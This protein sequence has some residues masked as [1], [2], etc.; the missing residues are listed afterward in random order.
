MGVAPPPQTKVTIAG[1]NDIC[2]REIWSGQFWYTKFWVPDPPP[3]SL[4]ILPCGRGGGGGETRPLGP[5]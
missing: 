4:L 3:P 5:G 1:K 2:K